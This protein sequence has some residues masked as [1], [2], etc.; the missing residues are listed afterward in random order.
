MLFSL[1]YHL[2]EIEKNKYKS[3]KKFLPNLGFDMVLAQD[4]VLRINAVPEGLKESAVIKFLEQIFEILDY[5]TED[6]FMTFYE[7]QWIK[8]QSKSKFDF[9]IKPK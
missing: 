8:V 5:R 7:E 2:N 9:Y 3:I 1:E 4:N 6:E